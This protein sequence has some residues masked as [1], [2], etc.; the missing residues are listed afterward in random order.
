MPNSKEHLNIKIPRLPQATQHA[1]QSVV[2]PHG[3]RIEVVNQEESPY[4]LLHLPEGT[5][6][7]PDGFL[8][9]KYEQRKITLPD[10]FQIVQSI[11]PEGWSTIRFP[12]E[13]LS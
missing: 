11:D 13:A 3:I 4:C 9:A 10:G 12:R 2:E 5:T 8:G 1:I 7:E 6:H